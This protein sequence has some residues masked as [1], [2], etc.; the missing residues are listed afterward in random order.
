MC[1][2]QFNRSPESTV[3]LVVLLDSLANISLLN[4]SDRGGQTKTIHSSILSHLD[5]GGHVVEKTEAF[6][7]IH[8]IPPNL[9]SGLRIRLLHAHTAEAISIRTFKPKLCIPKEFVQRLS[10]SCW[11]IKT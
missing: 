4:I 8:H 6:K 5:G 10:L 1:I 3:M 2:Y 11:P 9:S 7:A